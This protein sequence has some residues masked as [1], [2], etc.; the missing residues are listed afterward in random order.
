VRKAALLETVW[1]ETAVTEGV[2]TRCIRELRRALGDDARQARYIE[3]V[4]RRG[5]RFVGGLHPPP[6]PESPLRDASVTP[7][8]PPAPYTSAPPPLDPLIVGHEAELAHLSQRYTLAHK[9]QRQVLFVTGEAGMGKTT[10]VDVFTRRL[11]Q[12]GPGWTVA[13]PQ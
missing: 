13:G 4:H 8:R 12:D 11:G 2:L 3:T 5:Y 1:P 7:V 10:L 6:R 9:G